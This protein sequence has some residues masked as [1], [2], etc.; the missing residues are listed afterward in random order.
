MVG[1][2]DGGAPGYGGTGD[3]GRRRSHHAENSEIHSVYKTISLAAVAG[4]KPADPAEIAYT[5][6]PWFAGGQR[7]NAGGAARGARADAGVSG[8]NTKAGFECVPVDSCI[9]GNAECV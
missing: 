8:R 5:A 9:F 2:G 6:R 1:G 3:F 7:R 4:R